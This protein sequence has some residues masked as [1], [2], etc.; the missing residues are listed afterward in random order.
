MSWESFLIENMY[1]GLVTISLL[2]YIFNLALERIEAR[3]VPWAGR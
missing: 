1:V 3:L 2:G